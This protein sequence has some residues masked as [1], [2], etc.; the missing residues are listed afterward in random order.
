MEPPKVSG[1]LRYHNRR[2]AQCSASQV[3]SNVGAVFVGQLGKLRDGCQPSH[4][5]CDP[6]MAG[7]QPAAGCHPAPQ[8]RRN[9][10]AVMAEAVA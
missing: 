6:K 5:F 7:Y 3:L 4:A 10:D 9:M 2:D 8:P 1:V